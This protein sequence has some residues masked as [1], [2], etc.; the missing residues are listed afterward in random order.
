MVEGTGRE[1]MR[2]ADADR[3]QVADKLRTALEEGRLDLHEYDE[4][5]Q[6]AYAAKTYGDLNGLLTDLPA[7]GAVTPA[8][9]VTPAVVG[10]RN[11]AT[12]VYLAS[13]WSSW[14]FVVGLCT[15]IWGVISLAS[16]EAQYFWPVWVAVPWGLALGVATVGGLATGAPRKMADDR[17]R[18]ELARERR[19]ERRA[20]IR[21]AIA[22]GDLPDNPTKEQRRVFLDRAVAR[23]ELPPKPEKA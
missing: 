18:K 14:L 3:Q 5:V 21:Q 16:F 15:V 19:R 23:G 1:Q 8:A 17:A 13:V 6:Q 7:A 10:P 12:A 22:R 9:S 11:R 20:L 2:A 4:R